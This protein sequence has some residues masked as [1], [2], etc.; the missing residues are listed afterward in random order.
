MK[1]ESGVG[2]GYSVKVD[3]ENRMYVEAITKTSE[4]MANH[5]YGKAFSLV[6]QVTPTG[7]GDCFF[8]FKNNDD[9]DI[10]IEGL[11]AYVS[12]TEY[13]E[14]RIN[15]TGT[16]VGGTDLTPVIL[17][18]SSGFSPP[19]TCQYGVDITGLNAGDIAYRYFMVT[20]SGTKTINF[21]Q[22]IILKKNGVMTLWIQ[23]GTGAVGFNINA[24]FHK[25][26]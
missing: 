14:V 2:N 23:T 19:I 17:N 25:E 1:I 12:A 4:H 10:I 22:D 16:P 26:L 5:K 11:D 6:F 8:Y 18:T 15:N 20:G 3:S 13:F 21:D 9:E 7:A 24:H